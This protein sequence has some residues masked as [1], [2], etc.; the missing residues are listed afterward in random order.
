MLF[1][2]FSNALN[3]FQDCLFN[4][5]L[6]FSKN[7]WIWVEIIVTLIAFHALFEKELE[8]LIDWKNLRDGLKGNKVENYLAK[9]HSC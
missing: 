5:K 2:K 3:F 9:K 1:W 6:L 8:L 4:P 7:E